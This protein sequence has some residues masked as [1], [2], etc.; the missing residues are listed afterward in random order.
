M[1]RSTHSWDLESA[2]YTAD[3]AY[4]CTLGNQ[5]HQPDPLKINGKISFIGRERCQVFPT[6]FNI[7][8]VARCFG[9]CFKPSGNN[10]MVYYFYKT[11]ILPVSWKEGIRF[12][13]SSWRT[14]HKC[15]RPWRPLE[16]L[17]SSKSQSVEIYNERFFC[18]YNLNLIVA[19]TP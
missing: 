11:H 12:E 10:F 18:Q 16:N 3:D 5:A 17:S 19:Y 6:N 8:T 13:K 7:K 15:W 4:K 2:L 14:T 9:S 1:C